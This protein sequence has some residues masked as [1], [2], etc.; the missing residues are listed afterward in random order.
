[1]SFNWSSLLGNSS[2]NTSFFNGSTS[3]PG[4]PGDLVVKPGSTNVSSS[5]SN[6]SS[7]LPEVSFPSYK[8]PFKIPVP[9]ESYTASQE[10]NNQNFYSSLF[11]NK[12]NSLPLLYNGNPNPTN[13]YNQGQKVT[14]APSGV[15]SKQY[16][17]DI[18]MV[19]EHSSTIGSPYQG[20]SP[21]FTIPSTSGNIVVSAPYNPN[22]HGAVLPQVGLNLTN[23][24]GVPNFQTTTNVFSEYGTKFTPY[25]N[26]PVI[27]GLNN[28][29]SLN[30]KIGGNP[31]GPTGPNGLPVYTPPNPNFIP[32]FFTGLGSDF[33]NGINGL[34]TDFANGLNDIGSGLSSIGGDLLNGINTLGKD[35]LSGLESLLP[36]VALGIGIILILFLIIKSR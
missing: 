32:Q 29:G 28:N 22:Y 34:G 10:T 16:L 12:N 30:F 27:A 19:T 31:T 23:I 18:N 15:N 13:G 14:V 26:I 17:N 35:L 24:N 21:L 36:Y 5:I 33:V 9:S 2:I 3:I 6:V 11:N 7:I 4:I 8:I 25:E 20:T 1:M